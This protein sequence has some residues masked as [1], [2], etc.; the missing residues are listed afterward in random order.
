MLININCAELLSTQLEFLIY[1]IMFLRHELTA[2]RVL[3]SPLAII[4]D[5]EALIFRK[6]NT[7]VCLMYVKDVALNILVTIKRQIFSILTR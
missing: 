3:K 4:I 2:N 7:V 6:Q 5:H 1:I